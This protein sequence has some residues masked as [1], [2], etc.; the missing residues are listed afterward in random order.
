MIEETGG[1][2]YAWEFKW[3]GKAKVKIPAS[4]LEAY[5]GSITGLLSEMRRNDRKERVPIA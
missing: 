5:P 3:N 1:K 4:F 2:L